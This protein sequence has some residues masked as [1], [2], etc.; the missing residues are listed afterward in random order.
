MVLYKNKPK[1]KN[2]NH[3]ISIRNI[4]H[5]MYSY[6]FIYTA[7]TAGSVNPAAIYVVCTIYTLTNNDVPIQ[8][9]HHSSHIFA[10]IHLFTRSVTKS[11]ISTSPAKKLVAAT[12]GV[13]MFIHKLSP[14]HIT[15]IIIYPFIFA[16]NA[17]ATRN[18]GFCESR[19]HICRSYNLHPH[20]QRCVYKISHQKP[21]PSWRRYT[22]LSHPTTKSKISVRWINLCVGM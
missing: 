16:T 7:V 10:A 6:M 11:K 22:F 3:P 9:L 8:Y 18:G 17:C 4:V 14:S 2:P 1:N 12:Y 5:I 13:C 15:P 20:Q 21:Y 19:R